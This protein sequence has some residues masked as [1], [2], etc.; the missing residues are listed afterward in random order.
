MSGYHGSSEW[1]MLLVVVLK[2]NEVRLLCELLWLRRGSSLGHHPFMS[3]LGSIH[4]I[5][6]SVR[7][8]RGV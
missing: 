6:W 4:I 5:L 8:S 7:S 1:A 2:G 3:I